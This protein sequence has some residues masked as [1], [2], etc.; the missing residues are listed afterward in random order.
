M[1]IND[2]SDSDFFLVS[3]RDSNPGRSRFRGRSRESDIQDAVGHFRFNVLILKVE[4]S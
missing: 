3:L 2:L 4:I 1:L